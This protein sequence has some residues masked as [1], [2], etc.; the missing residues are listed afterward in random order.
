MED[1]HHGVGGHE[2]GQELAGELGEAGEEE[3]VGGGE[4]LPHHLLRHLAVVGVH[5]VDNTA[6]NWKHKL[7]RDRVQIHLLFTLRSNVL[8]LHDRKVILSTH[9]AFIKMIR[10][11]SP[12]I[13]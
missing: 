2:L 5:E 11:Q 10:Q 3:H 12:E 9:L 1:V 6:E 7:K 13:F 8:Y 4:E